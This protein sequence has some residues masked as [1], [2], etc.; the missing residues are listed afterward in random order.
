MLHQLLKNVQ[1]HAGV[2]QAFYRSFFMPVVRDVLYVLTDR[3]HKSGFPMHVAILSHMFGLVASG[4]VQAPLWESVG[5][6]APA[7]GTNASFLRHFT[8]S[9]LKGAFP[10]AS[11]AAVDGFASGL[12]DKARSSSEFKT[13]VRDFLIQLKVRMRRVEGSTACAEAVAPAHPGARQEF[14]SEDNRELYRE[15]MQQQAHAQQA[16]RAAVPGLVDDAEEEDDI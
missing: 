16:Q 13:H 6:A 2:S 3:L 1:S 14:A 12:C 11:T 5:S 7:E 9:L 8:A 10:H 4:E 15:E